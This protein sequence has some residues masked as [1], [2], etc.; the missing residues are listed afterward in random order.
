MGVSV[1]YSITLR[2]NNL[3]MRELRG[4]SEDSYKMLYSYLYM[5][6]Q[7]NF[8][9]TTRVELDEAGK[10]KYLFIALG[11]CIEGFKVMRK[12]ILVDATFLKNGYGGVLVFAKAQDPN[13]HHYPLAFGVLDGENNASWTW[14]FEILTTVIPDSSEIVFMSDRNQSLI[15]AVANVYP[16][17]HHGHCIW[18]LAQN[19]RN[20]ACN[21]IK[22]VVAW[23]FMELAR[24]YT[25]HEFET[26]YASFKV[27]Y[28][29][30]FKYVEENTNRETWVRV[31]FPGCRY[32][33]DTSNSVESMN[34]AFRDA[35]SMP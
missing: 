8:G 11:A 33:L 19:V 13:C 1:S 14:F 5:L 28:P 31:Y 4:N 34:S 12:V 3:A 30:A 17:S 29:S 25:V 35:R 7:V 26:A 32:N 23:R 24:Y 21:T 9:R 20:H 10:F 6:E 15:T 22:A 2:G 27:R 16:Q 18:H